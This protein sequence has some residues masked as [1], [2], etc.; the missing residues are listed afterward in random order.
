M[1]YPR[2]WRSIVENNITRISEEFG[3]KLTTPETEEDARNLYHRWLN[4]LA[5]RGEDL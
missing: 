5:L 1:R 2:Y 3:S 4:K